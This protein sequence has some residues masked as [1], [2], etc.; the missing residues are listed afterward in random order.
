MQLLPPSLEEMIPENH[1]V[2]VVNSIVN[3]ISIDSFIRTYQGGGRSS[4]E[5]RM[6]L[7]V[8]IYA[9]MINI[10][11]SRKIESLLNE[12][13]MFMWLSGFQHPDHNTINR[14]RLKL[15]TSIKPIFSE[16]VLMLHEAG[17]VDIKDIYTDGTKI[18][19]VANKYTFVWGKAIKTQKEKIR[20]QLDELWQYAEQVTKS[21]LLDTRP[22]CYEEVSA[23]KV[24]ATVD[25][26]NKALQ[27]QEID[28]KV[29]N[30]IK[31][32][33]KAWPE[34]LRRYEAQEKEL[35]GRGSF[36]KTDPDATFMRLKE[37]HMMNG[38][39]K[40]SYNVQISTNNQVITNFS[41]HQTTNDT[42][43]FISHIEEYKKLYKQN[44]DCITADAGY[45]SEENYKFAEDNNIE[46]F[47]KYNYFHKEQSR[48]WRKDI[49]C[50]ENLYYN[51]ELDCFYCPMGQPM[52]NIGESQTNT[53]TGFEQ[54]VMKYRALN[55]T[56][57]PLRGACNKSKTNRVIE[58][59]INAKRLKDKARENLMSERGIAKRKRRSIEPETVFGN[60]KRNKNFKRFMLRGITKVEVE[61]GLVAISHNLRKYRA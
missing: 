24:Q 25:N 20:K 11:S 26:I 60:I 40:P 15:R 53:K 44:P 5:P 16:I 59:N 38:Q 35:G 51:A 58:V 42:T 19:S 46:T 33:Q 31:R 49:H 41:I 47:I 61:F 55:C 30:K 28:Q 57:C 52:V 37:D 7:K 4:F 13:I 50:V 22:T 56:G 43:T 10:Y 27:G 2:R 8:L 17:M 6:L 54:V 34:N 39:L 32:V 12:N 29:R 3:Y 45:G 18:E 14:F 36:S 21:E 1:P 23:E 48:T 9:Y